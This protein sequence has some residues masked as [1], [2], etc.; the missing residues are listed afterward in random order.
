MFFLACIFKIYFSEENT[1]RETIVLEPQWLIDMFKQLNPQCEF[2]TEKRKAF[3]KWVDYDKYGILPT[4]LIGN[5]FVS[6]YV[7]FLNKL[8]FIF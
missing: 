1:L 5:V 7:I 2:F 3:D 4:S 8:S 6:G